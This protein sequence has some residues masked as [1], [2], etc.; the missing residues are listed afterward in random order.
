VSQYH[1]LLTLELPRLTHDLTKHLVA[2]R[3]RSFATG[4]RGRLGAE[5]DPAGPRVPVPDR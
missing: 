4:G 1:Q 3:L 2:H 5:S